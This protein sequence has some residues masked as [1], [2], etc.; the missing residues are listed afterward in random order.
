MPGSSPTATR[1]RHAARGLLLVIALAVSGIAGEAVWRVLVETKYRAQCAAFDNPLFVLTADEALYDL[2]P[3]ADVPHTIADPKGGPRTSVSYHVHADGLRA[4]P[5]WPPPADDTPRILFVGDSYTFGTGVEDGVA[6]PHPCE[7]LLHARGRRDFCINAG[8]PGHN[9]EQT[10]ARLRVLLPQFRPHHVVLGFVL[11]DA[12]PPTIAPIPPAAARGHARS[13]LFEDSKHV[14]N[15]IG[16]WFVS[17][18]PLLPVAALDYDGNALLSWTGPSPKG[19][20][21]LRAIAA[22]H[23]VCTAAGV[24]FSVVTIPSF[25]VPFDETYAFGGIHGQVVSQ[26]RALGGFA[27]DALDGLRGA[28]HEALLVPGDGHPNAAGHE[29][30]AALIAD[31][32]LEV[33]R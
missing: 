9:S 30:L 22:M 21:S 13:W 14:I 33:L 4:H 23:A 29:R 10:L 16:R 19:P 15:E 8:V 32:L 26:V 25:P 2:R 1:R 27:L 24:G 12:E 20:A 7:R 6:F 31:H 17:D 11:N 18:T 28:D 3:G 5:R